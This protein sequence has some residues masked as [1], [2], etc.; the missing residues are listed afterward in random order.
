MSERASTPSVDSGDSRP[1]DPLDA[2][3]E[4]LRGLTIGADFL[5]RAIEQSNRAFFVFA[6]DGTETF[7]VSPSF[8]TIWERPR[9]FLYENPARW[10]ETLHPDDRDSV[11][12]Q[13]TAYR[14]SADQP[15]AP[16]E[17]RI[18]LPGGGTRWIWGYLFVV[19]DPQGERTLLCGISEDVTQRKLAAQAERAD[20]EKLEAMVQLRTAELTELNKLLHQEIAQRKQTERNLREQQ[21]YL[22]HLLYAQDLERKFI[23]YDIHDGAI[24][25]VIAARMHL[26]SGLRNVAITHP[27]ASEIHEAHRLLESALAETR[28]IISGIRPPTLDDLGVAAALEELA[29]DNARQ[30]LLVDLRNT[31]G[32]V[33]WSPTL[34]M[35]IYRVVQESLSNVRRH[36]ETSDARVELVIKDQEIHVDITDFGRGFDTAH[37]AEREFGLRGIRERTAAVGGRCK[38]ISEPGKGTVVSVVVPTLDPEEMAKAAGERAERALHISRTRLEALLEYTPAV[39]F[40]KDDAGRYEFVNRR[41]SDLFHIDPAKFVGSTDF[42]LF[43]AEIAESLRRTDASVLERGEA[44]TIEESVPSDGT[45]REYVSVKF[46]IPGVDGSKS[47]LCGIATDITGRKDELLE[48]RESRNRF[49]SFMDHLPMLA[50]I[51]DEHG[52]YVYGNR[53][54]L[55]VQGISRDEL[56]GKTDF[57][58]FPADVAAHLREHDQEVLRANS[59]RF[60]SEE[61]PACGGPPVHWESIKFPVCGGDGAKLVG[62]IAFDVTRRYARQFSESPKSEPPAREGA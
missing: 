24:Q 62:G 8:E 25:N 53:C 47:S 11:L 55:E 20:K 4:R 46:P 51:K 21:D 48:L 30:G 43:P 23:S 2:A 27:G 7:Y 10:M 16:L 9:S 50:W 44:V 32:R 42:D 56:L 26:E 49:C 54:L 15:R 29:V 33:R 36:G 35:T 1:L 31:T 52:K 59:P 60:F 40:I 57:D 17:Y 34:E 39:V 14:L 58:I 5:R 18:V 6:P 13:A 45:M 61:A 28:R 12:A 19:G 3:L 22:K 37:V 41:Y 38:I